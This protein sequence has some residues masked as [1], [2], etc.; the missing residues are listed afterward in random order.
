MSGYDM[1]VRGLLCEAGFS[2]STF[3]WV[4]GSKNDSGH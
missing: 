2:T 1:E 3:T 4:L